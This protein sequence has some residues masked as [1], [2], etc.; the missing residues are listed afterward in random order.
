M[1]WERFTALCAAK[2]VKP[3][4]AGLQ[5][6]LSKG[7][8]S[9]WKRKYLSGVDAVPDS[10]TMR[11]IADYFDVPIDYLLGRADDAAKEAASLSR[12]AIDK[13]VTEIR[14]Y[15]TIP[16]GIPV[17][18]IEDA[19]GTEDIPTSWLD[20]HREFFALQVKGD[21]MYPQY[22]DGDVVIF[23]KSSTCETGDDCVVYV[24]GSDATFKRVR[25]GGG[26]LAEHMSSQPGVPSADILSCRSSVAS[27]YD[28]WRSCGTAPTCQQEMMRV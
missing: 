18:A 7:T 12:A 23:R 28:W 13:S 20:G 16:A 6:G 9:Y 5:M 14:V 22:L 10:S 19:V 11:V 24:N 2:G 3:T 21:S 8:I 25:R 1:F 15:G 26:R 27:G 17:E 4:P